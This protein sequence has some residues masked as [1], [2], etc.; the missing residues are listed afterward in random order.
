MR[1]E[2][3]IRERLRSEAAHLALTHRQRPVLRP[4]AYEALRTNLETTI[5]L[6]RWVLGEP[7]VP[8]R[9]ADPVLP[10]GGARRSVRGR[11]P[12]EAP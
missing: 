8:D 7:E 1:D 5:G 4:V 6:L 3:Q 10:D 9:G 2:S 12:A 11:V